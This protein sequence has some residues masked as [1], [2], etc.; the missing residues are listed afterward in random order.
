MREL[1]DIELDKLDAF[2]KANEDSA[3]QDRII[4]WEVYTKQ[5][6]QLLYTIITLQQKE[7]D[8]DIEITELESLTEQLRQVEG[9]RNQFKSEY[10]GGGDYVR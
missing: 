6:N 10:W 3:I 5:I 9:K 8:E 2:K 1:F 7:I 4:R